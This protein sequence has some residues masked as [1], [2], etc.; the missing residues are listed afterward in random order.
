MLVFVILITFLTV[1]IWLLLKEHRREKGDFYSRKTKLTKRIKELEKKEKLLAGKIEDFDKEISQLFAFYDTT[2]LISSIFDKEELTAAFT[3][4]IS[5]LEGVDR[6]SLSRLEGPNCHRFKIS[7]NNDYLYLDTQ[8]P[9]IFGLLP[10]FAKL[11]TVSLE[12]LELYQRLQELSIRDYLTGMYNRRFFNQR[13]EEEFL[14]SKK[15]NNN[16]SFL[17]IDLDNFKKINDT[18]GHLVGDAV[19][20]RCTFLISECVRQIDF[21]GRLGGEEFGVLLT[22]TDKAGAIMVSER[23]CSR[24][25]QEK[26]KVFDEKLSVTASIGVAAYPSN[27]IY[28]DLFT[29]IADKAL[30]KAKASGK[31]R[32]CWF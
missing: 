4:K 5:S 7:Q 14:R 6:I 17:M 22:D 27:T 16:L 31:D 8:A 15:L 30:Y 24:I 11:L 28:L 29:E 13:V 32:V 23:I 9:D 12:R 1:F 19:L 21:V 26:I 2:R 25:S 20:K 10:L 18:Y 3:E